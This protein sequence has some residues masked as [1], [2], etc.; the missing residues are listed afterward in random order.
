MQDAT[1][2]I[3][4]NGAHHVTIAAKRHSGHTAKAFFRRRLSAPTLK[5]HH[6]QRRK[7]LRTAKHSRVTIPRRCSVGN[8]ELA[9]SQDYA[10]MLALLAAHCSLYAVN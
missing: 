8:L 10:V 6:L 1:Q 9:V 3:D 2:C 7:S 5:R 4:V